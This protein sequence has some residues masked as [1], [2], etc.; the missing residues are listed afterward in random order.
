MHSVLA[1][2]SHRL[3]GLPKHGRGHAI[4]CGRLNALLAILPLT[5]AACASSQDDQFASVSPPRTLLVASMQEGAQANSGS[6]LDTWIRENLLLPRSNPWTQRDP[7]LLHLNAASA[8]IV[9]GNGKRL[10]SKN[11]TQIKPIASITKLMTAM[12]V[13]DAGVPL[14][15]PIT[16]IDADRDRLRNSRSRLRINEARLSRGELI[17]VAVMS[18]DNRA[19]HALARTTFPGGT[20]AFIDAM[21]RK[22][23]MLGMHNTHFA[24]SSGLNCN[25]RSSAEDLVKLVS[26]AARYPLIR[27]ITAKGEMTV[28]PFADGTPLLYR[29]SNPLARNTEWRLDV[30]KTGFINEAGYCLA[31]QARFDN[32]PVIMI[33]LGAS[34]AWARVSDSSQVRDWLLTGTPTS[35]S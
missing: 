33:F 22:A 18:S 11:A 34:G 25:N 13:L 17:A 20:P 35:G 23:K 26:A 1:L 21:N 9:D 32:R 30:S 2:F 31:M 14:R 24:D 15:T 8:L 6:E 4:R 3:N 28:R 16:I 12:V 27:E 29:N 5:L 7:S 19:A 10:Y